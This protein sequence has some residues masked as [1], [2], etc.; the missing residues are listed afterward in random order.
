VRE[1]PTVAL[2]VAA[3]LGERLRERD[4]PVRRGSASHE[5]IRS[6][7]AATVAPIKRSL[8]TKAIGMAL[9]IAVLAIGWNISP[10]EGLSAQGWRA[11]VS[12]AALIPLL[13]ADALPDGVSALLLGCVWVLGGI[14]SPTLAFSGFSSSS[15]VLL[16]S[17][18]I[19]GAAIASSGL[20]YR[21]ALWMVAHSGAASSAR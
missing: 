1:E 8:S 14:T 21:M 18:L 10:P 12:T 17:V 5:P 11:L 7:P 13:A 20:L 16:V 19:I 3:A 2:A 15:W 4:A 6:A 9:A